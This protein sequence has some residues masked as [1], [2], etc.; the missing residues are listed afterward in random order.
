M[1]DILHPWYSTSKTTLC[2]TTIFSLE[3]HIRSEDGSE[4]QGAFYVVN[5]PAWINVVAIT[6]E[7]KFILV[8]QF[9]HG[10]GSF[11]LEIVGGDTEEGEDPKEA[12]IRELREE[13]GYIIS[14]TSKV[15]LIGKTKPNPAFMNNTCFT[16]L[17]TD[18]VLG[19]N[20]Q[21]FDEYERIKIHLVSY[22]A[23]M[24]FIHNGTIDHALVLV[25][26]G[27]YR[28]NVLKV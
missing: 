3:E 17:M 27:W 25:A 9:R 11:E 16:Y 26:I 18:V 2:E 21:Q 23:L 13:T 24:E 12:A 4:K 19:P 6:L 1:T 28:M 20:G 5:A 10:S 7:G 15:E 14:P 8:E 22:E